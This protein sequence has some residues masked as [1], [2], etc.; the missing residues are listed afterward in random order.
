MSSTTY[1]TNLSTTTLLLIDSQTAFNHPTHWGPS[2][3]N[4]A[5]EQNITALLT[6]FRR[7]RSTLP[8][9]SRPSII[10]VRHASLDPNSPLFPDAE[11]FGWMPYSIPL[12]DEEVVTKRVNSA[13]IGT[14]LETRIR[15]RGTRRLVVAGLTT[16]HC[17]ST[18]VRMAG[19]LGVVNREGEGETGE[20]V[21][22]ADATAC[23]R[24]PGGVWDAETVWSV[25]VESLRE[26][27]EVWSTEEV[28]R[29]CVGEKVGER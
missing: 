15:A 14:D 19:N 10:H 21:L 5:Y 8:S 6:H 23:W 28:L 3:S 9:G 25:H 24:K 11:G 1:P 16:D 27:A 20:V 26:F 22:V 7:L 2:R 12:E 17:V 4:P 13:F 18:T 29:V